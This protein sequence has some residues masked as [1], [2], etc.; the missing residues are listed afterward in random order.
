[1]KKIKLFFVPAAVLLIASMLYSTC[2]LP[3]N[4]KKIVTGVYEQPTLRSA[5]EKPEHA[6]LNGS[7]ISVP[8]PALKLRNNSFSSSF[9]SKLLVFSPY[10]NL[11]SVKFPI[12]FFR[13]AR[14]NG[15]NYPLRLHLA[16]CVFRI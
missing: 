4:Y 7:P 15:T 9:Y 8:A 13:N 1:L 11:G 10:Y 12:T 16:F 2:F 14:V 6:L 3:V 5:S